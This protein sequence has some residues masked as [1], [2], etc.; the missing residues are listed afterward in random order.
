MDSVLMKNKIMLM[1]FSLPDKNFLFGRISVLGSVVLVCYLKLLFDIK[2][3]L[4]VYK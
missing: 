4:I 2:G 3:L 1:Q